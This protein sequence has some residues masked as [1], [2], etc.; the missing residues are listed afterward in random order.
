[1]TDRER[2][3]QKYRNRNLNNFK[4]GPSQWLLDHEDLL[5]ELPKGRGL[6]IAA[7]FGRNSFYLE[8]MGF[9]MDV[10]D[11]SDLAIE[12]IQTEAQKRAL[13]LHAYQLDLA[14]QPFPQLDYSLIICFN[15]L[16]RDLFTPIKTAL[17]PGGLVIY[18][19]VYVDDIEVL[20]S[21]MNP[22]YVLAKN[23]LLTVFHDFRI[24]GYRERVLTVNGRRKALASIVA[25]KH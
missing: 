9:E 13:K 24:L 20:G 16:F 1:M 17:N 11:V 21:T 12:W 14:N 19:T 18:E 8:K 4:S 25:Q 10:V 22:E 23:E 6:D 3:N 15:F 5:K 2:W 7:G